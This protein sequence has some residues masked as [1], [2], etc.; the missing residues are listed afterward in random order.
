MAALD[1]FPQRGQ[2][3]PV[4]FAEGP[5]NGVGRCLKMRGTELEAHRAASGMSKTCS[6]DTVKATIATLKHDCP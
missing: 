6:A 1:W 4:V 2:A 5:G 3:R